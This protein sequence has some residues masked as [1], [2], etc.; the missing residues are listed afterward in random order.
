MYY[1][2]Y[3]KDGREDHCGA[4]YGKDVDFLSIMAKVAIQDKMAD[5]IYLGNKAK[6]GKERMA[7]VEIKKVRGGK[8]G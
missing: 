2:Y 5:E 7:G 4:F 1:L 3:F 8:W 6:F